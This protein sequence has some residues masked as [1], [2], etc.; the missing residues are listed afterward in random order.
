MKG[1]NS[2]HV[3]TCECL[4][5]VNLTLSDMCIPLQAVY[6]KVVCLYLLPVIFFSTYRNFKIGSLQKNE[7]KKKKK[8]K[9]E[10]M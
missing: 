8:K 5:K 3:I 4:S 7:N 1:D 10:E 6:R 9:E 2:Q